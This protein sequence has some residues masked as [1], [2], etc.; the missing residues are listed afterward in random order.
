MLSLTGSNA[1]DPS[2]ISP[3]KLAIALALLAKLGGSAPSFPM[4]KFAAGIES[5]RGAASPQRFRPGGL[6]Q[7]RRQH[8]GGGERH[9]RTIGANGTTINWAVTSN[10]RKGVD[11]DMENWWPIGSTVPVGAVMGTIATRFTAMP[12]EKN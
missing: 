8:P 7:Q 11:A 5:C 3:P 4:P 6:R 10:Y 9:Q 2:P 12:M 1:D